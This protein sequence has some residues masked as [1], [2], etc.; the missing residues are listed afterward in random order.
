MRTILVLM[1]SLNR[2][3]LKAYNPIGEGITPNIDAF[4]RESVI[5]DNHFIG[6][7]PCMPARRDI[8]TGRMQ[9][10]E[11]NWGGIEPFDITLPEELRKH[12]IFTHITTDHQHYFEIG[13]ENYCQLFDTW[14]FHRGQEN[15]AWI[16]SVKRPKVDKKAYGRKSSQHILNKS[17]YGRKEDAY[18]TPKTFQSAC[19]WAKR[20]KGGDNF[21]L[22][23]EAFDPHEPFETPEQYLKLYKDDY[24]GPEFNWPGYTPMTE[25]KE[26]VEH[27]KKSYLATMTMADKWFGKFMA[28]LKENDL[29]EDTLIIFTTDHGHILGEH[30]YIGKNFMHAY[31]EL[32][33]IPLFVKMPKKEYAGEHRMQLTQN[34]DIMPTVLEYHDILVPKRVKGKNLLNYIEKQGRSREQIIYGWFG[35]GVNVYD[36][37]Y[38]YFRA[39]KS[40]ENQPCYEYC[41]IPTTLGR[42]MGEEYA[43]QI[44]MGRFLPYTKYPVYKIPVKEDRDWWGD[45]EPVMQSLL[46]NITEDYAQENP[47]KDGKHEQQMCEKLIAGMKEAQAPKEQYERLGLTGGSL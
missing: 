6:S 21:F 8:M 10:L 46:F 43:E 29:Y 44:K 38:T 18:P 14:D 39:P 12:G 24:Q 13:G 30:G 33:H 1:D 36:G 20:N 26:A 19:E 34:I 47:I 37:Q 5:F 4:S 17:V 45:L 2:R 15:D 9:F 41:G 11:R 7:A 25:P 3:F 40:K 22:M 42:Y 27:L 16:S 23:V 32:S 35:R 31:N 28:A